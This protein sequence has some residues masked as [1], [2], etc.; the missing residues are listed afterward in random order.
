VD[1]ENCV[2][3]F[4]ALK[5]SDYLGFQCLSFLSKLPHDWLDIA[6]F[7]RAHPKTPGVGT[8][9]FAST[10]KYAKQNSVSCINATIRADNVPGLAYY[11]KMGFKDYSVKEGVPLL[12]GT[13]VDRI[14]K[15][16]QLD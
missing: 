12:D 10:L 11:S 4:V 7:S 13:K 9:L 16:Y 14:S 1:G 6:T 15:K 2:S 5:D 8:A 3:T